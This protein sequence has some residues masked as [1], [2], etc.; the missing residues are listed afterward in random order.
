MHGIIYALFDAVFFMH[1]L[2]TTKAA[3]DNNATIIKTGPV[4]VCSVIDPFGGGESVKIVEKS[5]GE[6]NKW[7]LNEP[8]KKYNK[9]IK[10]YA[11]AN[12]DIK[13]GE[14]FSENNIFFKRTNSIGISHKDFN[15]Y[16][17]KK[18]LTDKKNDDLILP[19]DLDNK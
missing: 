15:H 2:Q 9:F 11:V 5:K 14:I 4:V 19:Q 1:A 8:K 16:R 13:K 12:S 6:K 17:G 3:K 7:N 10:K 18:F